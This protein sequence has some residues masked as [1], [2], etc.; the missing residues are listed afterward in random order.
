MLY[1]T[2]EQE[3]A[4]LCGRAIGITIRLPQI[5]L[6]HHPEFQNAV[7]QP[8]FACRAVGQI[9][10]PAV[11]LGL[12]TMF[13]D[14]GHHMAITVG[15]L[16]WWRIGVFFEIAV[17]YDLIAFFIGIDEVQNKGWVRLEPANILGWP[18]R[19][20]SAKRDGRPSCSRVTWTS[21]FNNS[22]SQNNG[23]SHNIDQ[24]CVNI[25]SCGNRGPGSGMGT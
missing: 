2:V 15:I 20:M 13:I 5:S 21:R 3:P 10:P 9:K 22:S 1:K 4:G 6:V 23:K 17:K 14:I 12:E 25:M 18:K 24:F 16:D 19:G 11:E 7:V 8:L